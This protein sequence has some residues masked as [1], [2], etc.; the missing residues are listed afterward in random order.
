MVDV[1]QTIKSSGAKFSYGCNLSIIF[2]VIQ[3]ASMVVYRC[4]RSAGQD[5]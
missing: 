1:I 2:R 4:G 3:A 5:F